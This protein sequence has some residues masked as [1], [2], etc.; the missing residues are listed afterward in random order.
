MGGISLT[1]GWLVAFRGAWSWSS[2]RRLS[3]QAQE[4]LAPR[5]PSF[6]AIIL[7]KGDPSEGRSS[8]EGRDAEAKFDVI[9]SK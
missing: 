5:P 3:L 2:F 7:Y 8:L 1:A 6:L 4:R 9:Y